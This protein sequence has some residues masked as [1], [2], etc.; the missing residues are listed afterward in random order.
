VKANEIRPCDVCKQPLM[1]GGHITFHKITFER[2]AVNMRA[3]NDRVGLSMVL[4]SNALA[5][6]FAPIADV[7][8]RVGDADHLLMCEN[9]AMKQHLPMVLAEAAA[10]R[11]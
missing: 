5:E 7:A 11:S 4:G 2:M 10:N 8:D 1:A 9:C 3:V 6:V